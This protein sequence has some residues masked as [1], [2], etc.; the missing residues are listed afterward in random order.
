MLLIKT[1]SLGDV[2]HTLPALQDA[3]QK[4]PG[5]QVDW[6]VEEAFA[7][8]PKWHPAVQK[9]IPVAWRRWR[10][11]LL[12][13]SVR[14]EMSVFRERLTK[15]HYDL[16]IDAQG[17]FKSAV[18]ARM[19]QG[20]RIGL[21][22]AS[23]REPV[24]SL[25]YNEGI[26]VPKG[27]HAISRLRTL[28]AKSFGYEVPENFAYGLSKE[29]WIHPEKL[30]QYWLF[31]HGTTWDTKLWPEEYW[32]ELAGLAVKSGKQVVLPWGNETERKRAARIT[33]GLEGAEVLPRMGINALMHYLA[34][35]EAIVG[36]D[37]GLSHVAAAMEIPAVAIYGATDHGLTGALGPQMEVMK[38]DFRCSPCM[39]RRCRLAGT[40]DVDPPCYQAV[41][42][43]RVFEFLGHKVG[44]CRSVQVG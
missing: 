6:V 7:E 42:P 17:L 44:D 9:V 40:G 41:N 29:R 25:F 30:G 19:A 26:H 12:S 21:D 23:C 33:D 37:T 36:V 4:V 15:K 22:G 27:T 18:I 34:H 5:L 1:S 16:V 3:Y 20:K 35:A 14:K 11:K 10:G 39:N 38:S 13:H 32:K 8:I 2:F 28:F 24:A 31:L 43:R